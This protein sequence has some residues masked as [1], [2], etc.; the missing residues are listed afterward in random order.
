[1]LSFDGTTEVEKQFFFF[2]TLSLFSLSLFSSLLFS[3]YYSAASAMGFACM[4]TS[5]IRMG[6]NG[7]VSSSTG[8]RSI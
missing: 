7:V 8:A 4:V 1:M 2:F 6:R 5:L 3:L